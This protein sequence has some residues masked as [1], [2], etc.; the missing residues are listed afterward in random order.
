MQMFTMVSLYYDGGPEGSKEKN[1]LKT[2]KDLKIFEIFAQIK[3]INLVY[4]IFSVIFK[5]F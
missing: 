2:K 3:H 5:S 4:A 1:I